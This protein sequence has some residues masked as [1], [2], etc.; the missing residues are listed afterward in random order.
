MSKLVPLM[1]EN[2]PYEVFL[3]GHETKVVRIQ[4]ELDV[5]RLNGFSGGSLDL[6]HIEIFQGNKMRLL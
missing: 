3:Q 1:N 6:I 2:G 4:T 5:P